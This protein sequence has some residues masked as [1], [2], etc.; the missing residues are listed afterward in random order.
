MSVHNNQRYCV[1][2]RSN[3]M[4]NRKKNGNRINDLTIRV[5]WRDTDQRHTLRSMQILIIKKRL[6]DAGRFNI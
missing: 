4:E 2:Y 5:S 3:R 1:Y 6:I